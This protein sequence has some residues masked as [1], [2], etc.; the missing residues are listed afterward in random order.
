MQNVE[1]WNVERRRQIAAYAQEGSDMA[2]CDDLQAATTEDVRNYLVVPN[3]ASCLNEVHYY[4]RGCQFMEIRN[5]RREL[6]GN[7]RYGIRG[8][9]RVGSCA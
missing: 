5:L 3:G 7:R 1:R 9:G 8:I 6:K 4:G 2:R